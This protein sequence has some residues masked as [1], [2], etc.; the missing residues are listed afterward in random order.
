MSKESKVGILAAISITILILGF[1]F[2][3]GKNVFTSTN[4]FYAVY[5]NID[6]L[7]SSNPVLIN[8]YRVGKVSSVS[9]NA[10]TKDVTVLVSLPKSI[11]VP[12]NSSLKIINIDLIGTKGVE[13]IFGDS[14]EIAASGDTL[15]AE[16]EPTLGAILDPLTQKVSSI[17][18]EVDNSLNAK[19]ISKAI[20]D[21]G[22]TL[23]SFKETSQNLNQLL[24]SNN[25]KINRTLNNFEAISKDLSGLSPQID[26]LVVDIK[27]TINNF[28]KLD[29]ETLS[30]SLNKTLEQINEITTAINDNKG[31]AGLLINSPEAHEKLTA[32]L[33]QLEILLKDIENN[34]RRYTGITER[35]RK[36]GDKKR[37]N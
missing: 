7:L 9:L 29:A 28:N 24:A 25:P 8:G 35:Q 18:G 2:M 37:D 33:K 12:K 11:I 15:K 20:K 1:N 19:D 4:K 10:Q 22:E 34:P 26:E 6:N 23:E 27:S 5:S 13:L 36:I 21:L 17:L 14:K 16:L 30:K 31:T 3:K 32:T